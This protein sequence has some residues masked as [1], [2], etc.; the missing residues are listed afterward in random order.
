MGTVSINPP[1][2]PVTEGSMG[3]ATATVPNVCKMPGPPAPFVPAPLPN[4]GKSGDSPKDYSKKVTIEGK[5]VAIK[6]ATFGSMGDVASKAT[7]GGMVS[8]NTHGPTKFVGP[9]SMDTK[10]EGKNVQLLG[11]PMLNNCGGSGSPPNAATLQGV[12]QTTGMVTAVEA[13]K[14]AICGKEH[15][16]EESE[17]TKID[18]GSLAS[19]FKTQLDLATAVGKTK[20]PVVKVSANTMLGVVHCVC[21]KKKYADQS[22][23]TTVELCNAAKAS[24]MEHYKDV[25]VSYAD[26][27]E[28]LDTAYAD[29]LNKVKKKMSDHH[30]NSETFNKAW[31]KAHD[32]SVASDKNRSGP[33][34]YPPGTCAAQGA[35]L[36]LMDDKAIPKAM[37]ERWYS[38]GGSKTQAPI[39]FIMVNPETGARETK[40]EKFKPGQTVPPCK[41]CVIL[42]PLLICDGG[43]DTCSH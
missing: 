23:M 28:A 15:K 21:G 16:L 43:K 35:L 24:G 19:N 38:S 25:T 36:L 22:A 40:V 13:A 12:I 11:D 3:M 10:I 5:K 37:T 26:G 18:A 9:G 1:K 17:Q 20:D 29:T 39:E 41:A 27:R 33:A 4:I 30:G 32:E 42:V 6:G 7:G 34:A 2:S 8:A 14:C 31:S